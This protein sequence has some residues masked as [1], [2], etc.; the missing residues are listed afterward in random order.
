MLWLV[1][2]ALAAEGTAGLEVV[3]LAV[4]EGCE[5]A[6]HD[7]S[8]QCKKGACAMT[9]S[10]ALAD[11]GCGAR[12]AFEG[13]SL[14]GGPEPLVSVDSGL[15]L[16]Q[17]CES[18]LLCV[19]RP[20][21]PIVVQRVVALSQ[22]E[23]TVG[24]LLADGSLE[25]TVTT[26]YEQQRAEGMTAVVGAPELKKPVE[27]KVPK[28]TRGARPTSVDY[29]GPV[30]AGLRDGP[31]EERHAARHP[32][33]RV[34]E[35]EE[36]IRVATGDWEAHTVV[37]DEGIARRVP[38]LSECPRE[39]DIETSS[40]GFIT[41]SC[42]W[43][44]EE[45]AHVLVASFRTDP[46]QLVS[47]GGA[48]NGRRDGESR[49]FWPDGSLRER[50]TYYEGRRV[51]LLQRWHEAGGRAAEAMFRPDGGV[52][53]E[54]DWAEDGALT[55]ES[56]RVAG[57]GANLWVRTYQSGRLI[58][59]SEPI[60][61]LQT[62]RHQWVDGSW[63]VQV[64]EVRRTPPPYG[65]CFA[66]IDCETGSCVDGAC[67][68]LEAPASRLGRD[69][70][71]AVDSTLRQRVEERGRAGWARRSLFGDEGEGCV[72]VSIRPGMALVLDSEL[73]T[74]SPLLGLTGADDQG[75]TWST[76]LRERTATCVDEP[77]YVA[78]EEGAGYR[79]CPAGAV[80]VHELSTPPEPRAVQPPGDVVRCE[81]SC[82]VSTCK[83]EAGRLAWFLRD[84]PLEGD[85]VE[86][87]R[88]HWEQATCE[89]E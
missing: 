51:G 71:F 35:Y 53:Y 74:A 89:A 48:R 67:R 36:G 24:L 75:A 29:Y 49:D 83:E 19:K 58:E 50:A 88:V 59:L 78:C 39:A 34:V 56:E 81:A 72:A 14:D 86:A 7:V 47:I 20:S 87:I 13:R 57:M 66:D 76:T 38:E 84:R 30:S 31:W 79:A 80:T 8:L 40:G 5:V 15:A 43:T 22:G 33:A 68:G 46:W 10:I 28:A 70:P 62:Q 52:L 41:Q 64:E 21:H 55:R 65:A 27:L 60:D 3:N 18:G 25:P 1:A 45:G 44:D 16:P 54:R 2:A 6:S 77:T 63:Q 4:V 12:V 73:G 69:R 37:N 82:P 42:T 23:S 9:E 61:A 85:A 11:P 26:A 17:P 32:I